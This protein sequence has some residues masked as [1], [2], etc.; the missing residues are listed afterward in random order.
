MGIGKFHI[1]I[2]DNESKNKSGWF[3]IFDSLI[4]LNYIERGIYEIEDTDN[5]NFRYTVFSNENK[6]TIYDVFR[7]LKENYD[8]YDLI[9]LDIDLINGGKPDFISY[10]KKSGIDQIQFSHPH[11]AGLSLINH[12]PKD[13]KPKIFFSGSEMAKEFFGYIRL[14]EKRFEDVLFKEVDD[15]N[16]LPDISEAISKYLTYRQLITCQTLSSQEV[17][18]CIDAIEA[19]DFQYL[20]QIPRGIEKGAMWSLKTLFPLQTTKIKNNQYKLENTSNLQGGTE[21]RLLEQ[22]ERLKF[23]MVSILSN[24]ARI[25]KNIRDLNH[26][27][28]QDV[29]QFKSYIEILKLREFKKYGKKSPSD[30]IISFIPI[31]VFFPSNE[32][33]LT[34]AFFRNLG[35]RIASTENFPFLKSITGYQTLVQEITYNLLNECGFYPGY[36]DYILKILFNNSRKRDQEINSI[37]CNKYEYHLSIEFSFNFNKCKKESIPSRNN[38]LQAYRNGVNASLDFEFSGSNS[39]GIQDIIKIVCLRYKGKFQFQIPNYEL[40]IYYDGI[41]LRGEIN[42]FKQKEIKQNHNEIK[43]TLIIPKLF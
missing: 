26:G 22:I 34:E 2:V 9:F 31:T 25:L 14:V 1:L 6:K 28:I 38:L 33:Q 19:M 42:D 15:F 39:E 5:C 16:S 36:L 13:L 24:Y 18:K 27:S 17:N 12:L 4:H 32:D 30:S 37:V 3:R 20:F 40:V 43:F 21:L 35:E 23:Q 29:L 8:T 11:L 7:A 41:E 10:D